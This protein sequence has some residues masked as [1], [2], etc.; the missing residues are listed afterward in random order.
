VV[1]ADYRKAA[2]RALWA[3]AAAAVL[4]ILAIGM[5]VV[6]GAKA[7]PG[8]LAVLGQICLRAWHALPR[9]VQGLA[10]VVVAA[11][12]AA[13]AFWILA[14]VKNW[15]QTRT[16]VR[17]LNRRSVSLPPG[18][19][20][21]LESL[22][23][24][25]HVIA[26]RDVRPYALT[27]GLVTPKIIV[28]T[29]LI[30][31]LDDD[32]LESVLLHERSHAVHRDPLALLFARTLA[33]GF[34]YLPIVKVLADRHRAAVE[35]AADQY[36]LARLS[37]P[38]SLSSAMLKLLDPAPA[39]APG[40]GFA[41]VTDVRLSHLLGDDV[42]LPGASPRALL[43]SVAAVAVVSAPVVGLYGLAWTVSVFPILGLCP[44]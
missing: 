9:V 17:S 31:T 37:D 8:T 36:A 43:G 4:T 26:V 29:R 38:V 44:A 3:A 25:N 13:G 32:E 6:L 33:A 23:I 24:R 14:A 42:D 7:V 16:Y 40:S 1:H 10:L 12:V 27:V 20:P 5:A 2:G 18:T 22:R 28:S 41:S 39:V 11:G 19:H 34:F 30:E 35:L 15:W 21:P